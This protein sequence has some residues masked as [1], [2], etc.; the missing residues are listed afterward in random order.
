VNELV[1]WLGWP[2]ELGAR[3]EKR[4]IDAFGLTI[5]TWH[6]VLELLPTLDHGPAW[7]ITILRDLCY[8]GREQRSSVSIPP[9]ILA[10]MCGL[11]GKWMRQTL[12]TWLRKPLVEA[13]AAD[14]DLGDRV[15]GPEKPHRY[16]VSFFDAI[17]SDD[18]SRASGTTPRSAQDDPSRASGT[19]VE[20]KWH[21][22]KPL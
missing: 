22:I 9:A 4:I 3:L 21:N 6:F 13:M 18:G 5:L 14:E 16:H 19:G 20:A 12:N 10:R 15:L 2:P 1:Q 17:L 11:Q 7:M 8:D